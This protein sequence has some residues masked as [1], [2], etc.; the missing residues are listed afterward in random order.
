MPS[1][2]NLKLTGSNSII[3]NKILTHPNVFK[4]KVFFQD[5]LKKPQ[6]TIQTVTQEPLKP[7]LWQKYHQLWLTTV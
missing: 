6:D 1:G 7:G 2:H 5:L 4:L 3:V